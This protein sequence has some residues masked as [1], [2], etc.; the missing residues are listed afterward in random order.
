MHSKRDKD[1]LSRFYVNDKK[2]FLNKLQTLN[3]TEIDKN[4]ELGETECF[5]FLQPSIHAS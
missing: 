1:I 5:F 3:F 2:N 4:L